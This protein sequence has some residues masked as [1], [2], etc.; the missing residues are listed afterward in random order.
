MG[1]EEDRNPWRDGGSGRDRKRELLRAAVET[2]G[3]QTGF[4]DGYEIPYDGAHF[5][6]EELQAEGFLRK[7]AEQ[8]I[9]DVTLWVAVT[10]GMRDA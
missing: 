8:P 3:V 2:G 9:A 4:C 6:A 1:F 5:H 10:P 7:H